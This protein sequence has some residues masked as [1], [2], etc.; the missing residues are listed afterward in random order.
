MPKTII[1]AHSALFDLGQLLPCSE[2]EAAKGN[3]LPPLLYTFFFCF[4][5]R[6]SGLTFSRRQK[7]RC[8][9]PLAWG[10]K[11]KTRIWEESRGSGREKRG[12]VS[13]GGDS[14]RA[15]PIPDFPKIREQMIG[16]GL[17][18]GRARITPLQ[19]EQDLFFIFSSFLLPFLKRSFSLGARCTFN[20]KRAFFCCN[21][22]PAQFL[23]WINPLNVLSFLIYWLQVFGV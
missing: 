13:P 2:Q 11:Q 12:P 21:L 5:L 4:F 23:C 14:G 15:L 6:K 19:R 18:E 16:N 3:V 22:F 1:Y 20:Y 9:S 10:F 17:A 7:R 8:L